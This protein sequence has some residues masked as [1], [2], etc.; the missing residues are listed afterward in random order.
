MKAQ[1][2]R[3]F[4]STAAM[5][6]IGKVKRSSILLGS[7]LFRPQPHSRCRDENQESPGQEGPKRIETSLVAF[8]V[9][10]E[11]SETDDYYMEHGENHVAHGRAKVAENSFEYRKYLVHVS[12]AAGYFSERFRIDR[13]AWLAGLEFVWRLVNAYPALIDDDD[14]IADRFDFFE[15]MSGQDDSLVFGHSLDKFFTSCLVGI[16]TISRL[17]RD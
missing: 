9:A 16:Q 1:A 14:S 4:P 12:F 8:I 7:F 13:G 6:G 10:G 17:I 15:D 5:G 11:Y 3:N 2:A